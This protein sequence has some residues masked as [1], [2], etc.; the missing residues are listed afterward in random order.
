M[1]Q[2][3]EVDDVLDFAIANEEEAAR[4]YTDLAKNA[5]TEAMRKAFEDFA[6][7]EAA[8]KA[9]L[10]DVKKGGE[11]LSSKAKVMDLK[12]SDYLVDVEAKPDMSYQDALVVAMKQ[13]K[14]AFRLY[15]DLAASITD[16]RLSEAFLAL[17]QEEA[18]H[19]LRF[20]IEY[21]DGV[22]TEG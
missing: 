3:S 11:V 8:H 9:K 20:E 13:E 5:R 21:D 10:L 14:A 22:L 7:E 4:F 15:T 1:K 2:W 12:L 19:K 16:D 6:R 17:A 18:K